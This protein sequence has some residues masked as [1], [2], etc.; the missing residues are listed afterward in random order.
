[1]KERRRKIRKPDSTRKAN[2]KLKIAIR[3]ERRAPLAV[4]AAARRDSESVPVPAWEYANSSTARWTASFLHHHS[5][6]KVDAHTIITLAVS[7]CTQP[8]R[9]STLRSGPR[10]TTSAPLNVLNN[11]G[12]GTAGFCWY[13]PRPPLVRASIDNLEDIKGVRRIRY[14]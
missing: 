2:F 14:R 11:V 6:L 8:S 10:T 5:S 13:P 7:T 3:E 12:G 9:L 4:P 1:M